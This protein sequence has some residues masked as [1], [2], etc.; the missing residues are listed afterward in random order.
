MTAPPINVKHLGRCDYEPVWRDMQKFTDERG[1]D[2]YDELWLVEHPPVFT[3]GLAGKPE[4]VLAA[5][6]IPV[7]QVDR[8]GQVTYHGPGQIVAYPMIDLRRHGIGVKSLVHGIEQAIIDTVG[9]YGITAARKD[10]APGVYVDGAKIA[11]LGLRIRK[12]CSF[13]GLAFNIDMDLEPFQRINPCGFSG[14]EVIQLADLAK[15]VE[16]K[17]VETQLLEAFC[18]QLKFTA[19]HVKAA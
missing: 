5:G 12:A 8:G 2:T 9:H 1:P 14:L 4:H 7:I 16:I 19:Q 18:D 13:H 10:N 11:S 3:Q 6:D 17:A 15:G